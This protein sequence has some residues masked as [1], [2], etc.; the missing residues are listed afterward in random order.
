[1]N[2]IIE[3]GGKQYRVAVGDSIYIEKL[4]FDIEQEVIFDKVLLIDT[5]V[6]N[7]YV[8]NAKVTGVVEK[9]GRGKKL[10]IFKIK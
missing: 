3:T 4:P 9:H 8:E 7:P 10:I 5:K 1:M 2:A 6:G